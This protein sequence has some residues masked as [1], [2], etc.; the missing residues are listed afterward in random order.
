MTIIVIV[1]VIVKAASVVADG[2]QVVVV[3]GQLLD[4]V[5][6]GELT[7]GVAGTVL[8]GVAVQVWHKVSVKTALCKIG[9]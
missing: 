1:L 9:A 3:P 6:V 4:R 5:E 7:L 2:V 8:E